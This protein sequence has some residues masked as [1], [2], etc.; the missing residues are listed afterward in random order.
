MGPG[1]GSSPQ[2]FPVIDDAY[3]GP[4]S[5]VIVFLKNS[6]GLQMTSYGAPYSASRERYVALTWNRNFRSLEI[7]SFIK[8]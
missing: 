3:S 6:Y 7:S 5:P 2:Y 8:P 4:V 1:P